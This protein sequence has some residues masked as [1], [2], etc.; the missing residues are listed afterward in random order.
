MKKVYQTIVDSEIGNCMQAVVASLFEIEL[1]SIPNF[2]EHENW[3]ELFDQVYTDNG[4][5]DYIYFDTR[6]LSLKLIK[7][8]LE[9]DKGI[10]GFF[11]ATVASQTLKGI[12]HAVVIDKNCNIVHDPNPNQLALKLNWSDVQQIRTHSHNWSIR[13]NKLNKLGN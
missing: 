7:N 12:T 8:I 2:V 4:Y 10:N 13:E 6:N 5:P 1:D 11:Y 3:G 9:H